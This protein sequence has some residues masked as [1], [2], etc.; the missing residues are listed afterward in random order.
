MLA[1]YKA[2]A[3]VDWEY[4]SHNPWLA[5][6][7]D[8]AAA[9]QYNYGFSYTLPATSFTSVRA[10]MNLGDFQVS[11]FCDNLFDSHTHD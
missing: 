8:P 3:R 11:A 5:P 9:A 6:V 1:G 4:T 2:F 7:Q 10:G